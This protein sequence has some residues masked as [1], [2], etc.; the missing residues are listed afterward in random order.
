MAAAIEP[1]AILAP[2]AGGVDVHLG[3]AQVAADPSDIALFLEA[4]PTEA[5]PTEFDETPS[6]AVE[7][8]PAVY[9]C[10]LCGL[11]YKDF[12][13]NSQA[14]ATCFTLESCAKVEV[15]SSPQRCVFVCIC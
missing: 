11:S 2:P 3:L 1:H 5:K 14:H 4:E 12:R 15:V 8:I 9:D 6:V 13:L 7:Q 10:A